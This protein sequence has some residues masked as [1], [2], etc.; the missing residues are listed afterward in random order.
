M[1]SL[2]WNCVT[3]VFMVGGLSGLSLTVAVWGGSLGIPAFLATRVVLG[4][5]GIGLL[6]A[7]LTL[8]LMMILDYRRGG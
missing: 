6:G 5:V 8:L 2:I 7:M 4:L 3:V 1:I